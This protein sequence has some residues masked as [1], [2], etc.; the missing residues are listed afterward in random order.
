VE[1][2]NGGCSEWLKESP[3]TTRVRHRTLNKST[4]EADTHDGLLPLSAEFVLGVAHFRAVEAKDKR[5]HAMKHARVN[6]APSR[7]L[8]VA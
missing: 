7:I 2:T 8:A 4:K 5:P 6:D 1:D 3:P